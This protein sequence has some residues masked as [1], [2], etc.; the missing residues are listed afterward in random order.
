MKSDQIPLFE[1]NRHENV[2]SAHCR[3]EQMSG[4]HRR[5][6]PERHQ[7][8]EVNWMTHR[9]VHPGRPETRR[10]IRPPLEPIPCLLQSEQIEMVDQERGQHQVR[11]CAPEQHMQNRADS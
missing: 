10:Y 3:E 11:P 5:R 2:S 7:K 4:G 9:L 1:L 8:T 6:A